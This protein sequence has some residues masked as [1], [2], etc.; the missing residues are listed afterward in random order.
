VPDFLQGRAQG[1]VTAEYGMLPG[2]TGTRKARDRGGKID[3]RT[4]EI[5]RLV[6]RALR[7]VVD[8]ELLGERSIWVDCDVLQA[9]GGTR[10]ASIT[11]AWVAVHDALRWLEGEGVRFPKWPLRD[12]VAA[13]SVGVVNGECRLDLVYQEDSKAEVDLNLVMTGDGRYVEVQ[14]TAEG[15]PF[16]EDRLQAM[17]ALGRKGIEALVRAQGEAI[18]A[19]IPKRG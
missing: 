10:T 4:V 13:V 2:S 17:L 18:A 6:G 16:P 15:R 8:L 19:P 7:A 14:G 9:D 11:G 12:R 3:G 5:Q 1:W